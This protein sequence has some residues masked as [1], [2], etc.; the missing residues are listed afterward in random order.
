MMSVTFAVVSSVMDQQ[1]SNFERAVLW[2]VWIIYIGSI[3]FFVQ[4]H[5]PWAD[6]AQSWLL[7]RDSSLIDLFRTHLRYEGTSGLWH[8]LLMIPSR[9]LPYEAINYI[10][11]VVAISGIHLL[12]F[13]SPFPTLIKVLLPFS[14]FLFYQYGIIGR[15]YCL[16]IPLLFGLAA[17]EQRR[18]TRPLTW[19]LVLILISHVSL[20]GS[21]IA[22]AIITDHL[23][24]MYGKNDWEGSQK[25]LSILG[26]ALFTINGILLLSILMPAADYQ[27]TAYGYQIDLRHLL[28]HGNRTMIAVFSGF[29][30]LS[31][32]VL[33]ISLLWF[34]IRGKLLLFAFGAALLIVLFS[35][36]YFPWHQGIL[37]I[38]WLYVLWISA[39]T[40]D[41]VNW[42]TN[43]GQL[44]LISILLVS[45]VHIHWNVSSLRCDHSS[46]YSGSKELAEYIQAKDLEGSY[47]YAYTYWAMAVLPYFENNI[48]SSPGY[49]DG[50]SFWLHRNKFKLHDDLFDV[51]ATWPDVLIIPKPTD[52]YVPDELSCYSDPLIFSGAVCWKNG[53]NEDLSYKVYVYDGK[54]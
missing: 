32:I 21:L 1:R 54:E 33:A 17:L 35:I 27:P 38:F 16:L 45:A 52:Y 46:T 19:T 29:S 51:L 44:T 47:I 2:S 9:L 34:A 5:E 22:L 15:S 20:H 48:Y 23:I 3:L 18:W 4:F 26:V 42:R 40:D 14:L 36:Y 53:R 6:E 24:R 7:A 10:S 37:F 12:L 50:S 25:R 30:V 11:A 39:P 43:I 28:A 8:V 31:Y 41:R 49:Q 13:R